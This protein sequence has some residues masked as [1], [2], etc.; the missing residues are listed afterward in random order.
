LRPTDPSLGAASLLLMV[1][2]PWGGWIPTA[3]AQ[4]PVRTGMSCVQ[5]EDAKPVSLR[6]AIAQA[7]TDQPQLIIAQQNLSEAHA[8]VVSAVSGF[9][10]AAQASLTDQRYAPSNSE[11]P[12]VVIGSTV[13]GG[14][15]TDSAYAALNITWNLFGSGRDVAAFR[16]ALAGARSS[17]AALD[18]QMSDTLSATLQAYADLY[19]AQV[20]LDHQSAETAALRA[21]AAR[22]EERYRSGDGTTVAIGQARAA[23]FDAERSLNQQCRGV[24]DKAQKLAQ[25]IGMH[26]TP[27]TALRVEGTLPPL[28]APDPATLDLEHLVEAEPA[29]VAAW[30]KIA[31]AAQKL[32]QEESEFGPSISLT[33][34]RDYLAQNPDSFGE[35]N[36]HIAPNGTM[37]ALSIQQ[38]LFPL[39]SESA[40]VQ[41]ARAE[42]RKAKAAYEQ[43]RL[44]TEGRMQTALNA[45]REAV[46]SYAAARSSLEESEQVLALTQ[47]LYAAGRTDL[48]SVDRSRIDVDKAQADLKTLSSQK[49]SAAWMTLRALQPEGF[50]PLLFQALRLQVQG[51]D[52]KYGREGTSGTAFEPP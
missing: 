9:L 19:E 22:A 49:L 20:A 24:Y 14:P 23:A 4:Q 6:E 7:I 33:A 3:A 48:D 8:D 31:A 18:S 13:L 1:L 36:R 15:Q 44:D 47:S 17:A 12:V 32:R 28:N 43:A 50:A 34:R 37:I 29:V 11:A 5:A 2:P 46:S 41:R 21:I 39:L 52:G 27:G 35:A 45:T 30:E 42:W 40:D 25:S 38:P 51:P 26:L 16:G 10:P